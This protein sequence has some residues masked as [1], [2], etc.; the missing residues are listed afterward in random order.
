M[1]KCNVTVCGNISRSAEE[2]TSH[3]GNKFISFPIVIHL[4]GKDLTVKELYIT[5]AAPGDQATVAQFSTGRKIK[6]SG[7]LY[8]RK[9]EGTTYFNLRTDSAIEICESSIP[10]CFTGN[11]EF[12]GKISKDGVKEIRSKKGK[13][14]QSFS[15][16]SSDI[17][18]DKREFTWVNF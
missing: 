3:E 9:H 8:V 10:D 15:A 11:M 5:I 2:K 14:F 16:F 18:G 1:I 7:I 6:A 13:E 4:Q 17:D 12:R